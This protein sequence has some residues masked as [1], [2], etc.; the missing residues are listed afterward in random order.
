MCV[1]VCVCADGL[2]EYCVDKVSSAA[3]SRDTC[4]L[5]ECL[6]HCLMQ[7]KRYCV[8]IIL[9]TYNCF[10][11]AYIQLQLPVRVRGVMTQGRPPR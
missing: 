2:V 1:C 8:N 7:S 11:S 10:C 6:F 4:H 5:L 9:C 3:L